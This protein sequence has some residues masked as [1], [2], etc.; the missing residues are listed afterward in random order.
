MYQPLGIEHHVN[1]WLAH[2]NSLT[3]DTVKTKAKQF[4]NDYLHLAKSR[5][6]I[7]DPRRGEYAFQVSCGNVTFIIFAY[8]LTCLSMT[9]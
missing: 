4:A 8:L 7:W 3:W 6:T 9:R 2:L 1:E 5:W